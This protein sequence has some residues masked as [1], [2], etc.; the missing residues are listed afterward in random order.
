M[1]RFSFIH[2]ADIH[3]DSA[4]IAGV[5]SG[6]GEPVFP[7]GM[8]GGTRDQ[9]YLALRIAGIEK[10]IGSF[11]PLP[12]IVDDIL[13]QFDD[14]RA[15]AAFKVLGELSGKTQVI[16]FTHNH[17]FVDIAGENTGTFQPFVHEL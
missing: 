11:E 4:A 17:H 14:E 5:R 3:L 9:L 10:Y 12:F 2:A 15:K 6:T 8:S 7:E 1:T 16:F 13:V